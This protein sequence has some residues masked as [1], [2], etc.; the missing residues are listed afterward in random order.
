MTGET[1][2]ALAALYMDVVPKAM[3]EFRKEMRSSRSV[4]LTVPQFRILAL[5]AEG[6]GGN[7]ELAENVGVS[8]AAMSRMVDWLSRHGLVERLENK[9]DRRK[10]QVQLTGEGRQH[11]ARFRKEARLRLQKRLAL[12][13]TSNRKKLSKGLSALALAV[14]SMGNA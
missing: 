11:F 12:L 4:C 1:S 10:V 14:E 9:S 13:N 6:P 8:V 7:R 3:R 2:A 5:L